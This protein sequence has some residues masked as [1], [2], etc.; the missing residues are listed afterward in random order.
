[1]PST[2]DRGPDVVAHRALVTEV[3]RRERTLA[4][5]HDHRIFAAEPFAAAPQFFGDVRG[6][7]VPAQPHV[8][9]REVARD[10]RQIRI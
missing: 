3:R 6:H 10:V 7:R 8:D 4:P 1:M 5:G 2:G 9:H